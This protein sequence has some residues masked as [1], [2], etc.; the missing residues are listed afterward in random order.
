MNVAWDSAGK[1]VSYEGEPVRLDNTTK[2]DTTLVKEVAA[3]REPFDIM[4]QE[5]ALI[6]IFIRSPYLI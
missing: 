4:A 2:Q 3:W 6:P 1:I 5:S